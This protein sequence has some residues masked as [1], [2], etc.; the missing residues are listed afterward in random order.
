MENISEAADKALS[1]APSRLSPETV[2]KKNGVSI[3]EFAG[4]VEIQQKLVPA[5][6]AEP[7]RKNSDIVIK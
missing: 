5:A 6:F 4:F 2:N 1:L 3:L 7:A